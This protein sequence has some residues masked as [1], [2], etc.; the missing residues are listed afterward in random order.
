MKAENE[1]NFSIGVNKSDIV[2]NDI[3]II[4][5]IQRM[6]NL[7]SDATGVASIITNSDGTPITKPSNFCSLCSLIRKTE[8]G[9]TNCIN[10]D[11]ENF[12]KISSEFKLQSCLNVGLWYTGTKILVNGIHV[13]NWMIGQVRDEKI[14]QQKIIDYANEIGA[15]VDEMLEALNNVPVMKKEKLGNIL[16]MMSFIAN[17]YADNVF[18]NLELKNQIEEQ[19]HTNELLHKNEELLSITLQSI[20][21]GVISTDKNGLIVNM[22]PVAEHLCGWKLQDAK[23][24]HLNLVFNIINVDSRKAVENPV[25]KVIETNKIIGLANHTILVSKDGT[26]YQISDSA[27]PIKNKNGIISGVVLVFSD[28]TEKYQTEKNLIESE[29]SKS[30]LLANLPGMAYRRKYDRPWTMEYVSEGFTELTGYAIDNVID[31]RILSFNDLILPEYSDYLWN[32]WERAVQNHEICQVEYKILTADK[33]VKWVW[34]QGI[35]IYNTDGEVE[36]LEGL[37][38]DITERKNA[39]DALQNERLLLRTLIDNIPD[40]IYTKDL[41]SRKTLA[42]KAEVKVLGGKS[43]DEVL[44]KDDFDLYPKELAEKFYADDQLVFKTG[45]PMLNNEE[46]LLDHDGNNHWM[47]FSKMLLR[48]KDNKV[49]G[50]LGIGHDITDRKLMEEKLQNERLLLRTL[51]DNIPDTIYAK[52]LEGRKTLANKAEVQLLGANLEADVIG[53]TDYEFYPKEFADNFMNDDKLVIETGVPDF[54]KEGLIIDLKGEKNW[55][56]SSKLPLRDKDNKII[57]VMGIGRNIT[58]RKQTEDAL[59]ESENF[60]KQT[61]IIAQLGTYTLDISKNWWTSSEVLDTIFGIDKEHIKTFQSWASIVHPEWQKIMTDH[62][63]IDVLQNKNKFDKVYKIIRQNDKEERWVH[64]LGALVFDDKGSPL[65]MIGTIQDITE[66]KMTEEALVKSEKK[67]RTIFENVMDVFYRIDLDG[68][69]LE[70]SPSAAYYTD[71]NLEDIIGS[72]MSNLYSNQEDRD[73]IR[74]TLFTVGELRDYE[75]DI[76]SKTGVVKHVSINARVNKDAQGN[77]THIDGAVRDI[78]LRKEAE[79]L[80]RASELKFKSYVEF[81]P[82]GVFVANELGRCIEV[83]SAASI[84]TGYS[85]EELILINPQDL[86]SP[87]SDVKFIEHFRTAI[88]AGFAKDEFGIIMKNGTNRYV[89]VDTVKISEQ[90]YLGFVVDIT[91]RKK[92]EDKLIENE[93]FLKETQHIAHLGNCMIDIAS[94][95]WKSSEILDS[96]FGINSQ[97]DKTLKTLESLIHPDWRKSIND[98]FIQGVSN[99]KIK[100]NKEFKIIRPID[101]EERWIHAIGELKYDVNN[102]PFKLIATVQDITDQKNS[103]EALRLSEELYRS[104]LLA[105]PDAIVLIE[106][107]G[108]IRMVSPATLLMYKCDSESQLIGRNMFDFIAPEDVER[109]KINA[110]R[111]FEG[112]LGTVEYSILRNNGEKFFADVNGDIT[113][114]S[115]G[116][117]TGMIFII[118]D[119]NE[120]KRA[121]ED[122]Y[123]EQVLMK[124]FMES[125]PGIFYLYSYPDL[126]LVRWNKNHETLFGFDSDEMKN[127][128]LLEWHLPEKKELVLDSVEGIMR[129]GQDMIEAQLLT[130]YG[131]SIPFIITGVKL[132]IGG[133]KF[134]MGVGIDNEKR[135]LAEE[136]LKSSQEQLQKFASHLQSVREEEKIML[137]REIHDELG[138]ILIAIKIE[139]G[140]MKQKILKSIKYTDVEDILTIFDNL[141]GLVDNTIKTTRKIMTD[142]RPEVLYLLGFVEAVKRQVNKF[143]ERH[144]INCYFDSSV[145]N[146]ELNTQQSVAL[147]RI[148]QESLNNVAKH[149]KATSVQIEINRIDDKLIMQISDNGIGINEDNKIKIDSFGLIG[150]KERVFLL[151][152]ELF[153]LSEPQKGTTIKVEIPYAVSDNEF[154]EVV[155]K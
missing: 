84:I 57:G 80:L 118:R 107:D 14:D 70:V 121:E 102:K 97:Y 91:Q 77:P 106:M 61:Q 5:E 148:L 124:T 67:Y 56:L 2:F 87:E 35:A 83:N 94:G 151:G 109:A 74:K 113:W 139:M 49:I 138:Q 72:S 12:S 100:L 88:K 78:T 43:E 16:E 59:K 133:Q 111:M 71:F 117:P 23:G 51:I 17:N 4:D 134:L 125:L 22:N 8:K 149:S 13:A 60:L 76:K 36:A 98:Y 90:L 126:K 64:G 30:V 26:E 53:K 130:K 21:D 93:I 153:I 85:K 128:S 127:R 52:D 69:I 9:L 154:K 86:I 7:F 108:T 31:N 6:Q 123:R 68:N 3:F 116:L 92:A 136:A 129:D 122:L 79:N 65:Y 1:L 45:K 132:E 18:K 145:T 38:I 32:E 48:D 66:L 28:V 140:M 42:N 104:I 143:Q 120:R 95:T 34:E 44:G 152:G 75:L 141:F 135:K 137:A 147:F 112:Y 46:L 89:S 19:K 82:H 115:D 144:K 131:S 24:K 15:N 105:S 37:I 33:T 11:A 155:E 73:F 54:N 25:Q 58:I 39:E 96:I 99:K 41:N 55:L 150:M 20:G 47:M 40:L 110:Y 114:S 50:L 119:V 10:A 142:L 146:I 101:K 63:L 81:A 103:A 62:F 29:R 27:A